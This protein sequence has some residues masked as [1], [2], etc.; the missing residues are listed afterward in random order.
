MEGTVED[1]NPSKTGI[2]FTGLIMVAG[3]TNPAYLGEA[4]D[5]YLEKHLP[6]LDISASLGFP[7]K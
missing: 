4:A 5:C 3:W 6:F 1:H 2:I 7:P